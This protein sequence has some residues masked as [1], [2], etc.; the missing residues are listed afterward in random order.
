MDF[1][2]T[3]E[4]DRLCETVEAFARQQL[5]ADMVARD[6]HGQFAAELWVRFGSFGIQGLPFPADYGGGGRDAVTTVMAMETLGRILPDNGLVFA[7]GAQMWSVQMP[8]HRFGTSA[9]KERFLAPLCRGERIGAHAMTEP[10]SGSDAFS[11]QTRAHR[12]RGGYRLEGSKTFITNAPCADLFVVFARTSDA[13]GSL[14][15]SA[16][17]V[18]RD[19]PGL[20]VGEEIRKM[21]LR[22]VPMSTV[23]FA[24]CVVPEENRLGEEGRG[25]GVFLD[26]IEWERACLMAGAVGAMDRLLD[27]SLR[28]AKQRR[29]F[30]QPIGSFGAVASRLADMKTRLETARLILYR[31]AWSKEHETQPGTW[32]A[33]AKLSIS[34]AYRNSALDAMDLH[35]GYGY[36]TDYEIEREVRDALGGTIYSGTSDI[37]RVVISRGLGLRHDRT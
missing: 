13:A 35:G 3:P 6:Q 15:I 32:A 12:H 30:G 8:I 28:H 16:F 1:R 7:L 37:Q 9:Q 17:L 4:Q 5:P 25:A 27:H 20:V 14:G 23:T 31:A 18:E 26:S 24:E 29:Q 34:E 22:T 36:T 19:T 11:L 2:R 21:G 10:S 33:M